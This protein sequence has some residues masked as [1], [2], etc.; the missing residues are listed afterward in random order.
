MYLFI[1]TALF[2]YNSCARVQFIVLSWWF[3]GVGDVS[4]CVYGGGGD[5]DGD[6]ICHAPP[7][8]PPPPPPVPQDCIEPTEALMYF[9]EV[10]KKR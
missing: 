1:S 10:F 9:T 5:D 4:M 7:P 3:V 8:P 2:I 6:G